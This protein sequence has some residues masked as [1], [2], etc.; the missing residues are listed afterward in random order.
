MRLEGKTV[1]VTGAGSGI[2]E[3]VVRRFV[4]EG[5]SVVA[6]GRRAEPL[7]ALAA[8]TGGAPTPQQRADDERFADDLSAEILDVLGLQVV[9]VDDDGSMTVRITPEDA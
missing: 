2:G 5:A 6:L 3:A 9:A 7:E 4:A 1:L 8:E